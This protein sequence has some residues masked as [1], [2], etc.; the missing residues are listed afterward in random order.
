MN[1]PLVHTIVINNV[2]THLVLMSADVIATLLSI[3]TDELA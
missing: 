1:V 2:I 3:M